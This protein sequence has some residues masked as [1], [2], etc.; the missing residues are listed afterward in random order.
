MDVLML[1]LK[2]GNE[3][4]VLISTFRTSE[5]SAPDFLIWNLKTVKCTSR[6]KMS[7]FFMLIVIGTLDI[8]FS[9]IFIKMSYMHGQQSFV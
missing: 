1:H 2:T 4:L 5:F 6:F 7:F 8:V 9:L 3:S